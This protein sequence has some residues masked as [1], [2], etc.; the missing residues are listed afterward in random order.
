VRTRPTQ[1][2]RKTYG[3]SV[4][5]PLRE[6]RHSRS[7]NTHARVTQDLRRGVTIARES[8]S[9][10]NGTT[11]APDVFRPAKTHKSLNRKSRGLTRTAPQP[12]RVYRRGD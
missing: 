9:S 7:P 5:V 3:V 11:R 12:T 2:S 10:G 1:E 6:E 8:R 4:Y